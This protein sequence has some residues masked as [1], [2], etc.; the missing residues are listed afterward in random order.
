MHG[1]SRQTGP[2]PAPEAPAQTPAVRQVVVPE[3]RDG[4]RLDNFLFGLLKGVPKTHVYRLLRTGQVRINGKRCKPDTRLAAGDS[5]RVPPVRVASP[6]ELPKASERSLDSLASRIVF[7]DRNF[8]AIDKPSGLA[9]HGGSGIKLGAI[10]QLRQLRPAES[11]ELVH[12]LDRDTSGVLLFARRRSGLNAVQTEIREGR[13]RKRYLALLAGRLP[14]DRMRV[15]APL[16]KSVLQGGERMVRVDPEG[17]P[18]RS[19]FKV[20]QR[21][22]D[23]SYVEIVIDTGRTHQIRVHAQHLGAP[24]AGDDKYGDAAANRALRERGLRR[25]FLHAA[26]FAFRLP[27]GGDY[28]LDAPLPDELARVLEAL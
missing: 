14:Q 3:D 10:E 6:G 12:R 15:D 4:Q 18:S 27:D 2:I 22:G 21:Y 24:V 25:L 13:V 16:R 23:Y 26:E 19:D 9:S 28:H 17:K 20:L 8:I 11:L 5:I 1:K 7:E